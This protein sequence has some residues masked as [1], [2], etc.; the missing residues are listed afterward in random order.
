MTKEEILKVGSQV[1][2]TQGRPDYTKGLYKQSNKL[3]ENCRILDIGGQIGGSAIVF[4]LTVKERGGLVYSIN[5]GF[6]RREQWPEKYK[7]YEKKNKIA[8]DLQSFMD[9][10]TKFSAEGYVIPLL[11]SSEE[12]LNRWDN[13]LFDMIYVDACH[14]YEAAKVDCKWLEHTKNNALA[15]FDDFGSGVQK[16]ATEYFAS[17]SEWKSC[18][19][20]G[21]TSYK[22]GNIS[23]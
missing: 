16:A 1:Y 2:G 8:G 10:V 22:K 5:P 13:R 23:N 20:Y 21:I 12:V 18:E 9:N 11:G 6:V 17:H 19:K 3:P 4:A 14:T 7:E 15:C